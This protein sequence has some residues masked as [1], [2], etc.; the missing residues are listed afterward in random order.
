MASGGGGF[1]WYFRSNNGQVIIWAG[2]FGG[3]RCFVRIMAGIFFLVG[4]PIAVLSRGGLAMLTMEVKMVIRFRLRDGYGAG[5]GWGSLDF[6][7]FLFCF[8]LN[9][10]VVISSTR[11]PLD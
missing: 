11:T 10:F 7:G 2:G 5:F 4:S 8:L 3:D 6:W 1:W 9:L